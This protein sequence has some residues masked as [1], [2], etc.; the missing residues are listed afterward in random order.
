M[1]PLATGLR[2]SATRWSRTAGLLCI[3]IAFAVVAIAAFSSDAV[4]SSVFRSGQIPGDLRKAINISEVFAHGFGAAAILG[5][6]LLLSPQKRPVIWTAIAITVVS[7]G[8]A[9][10]LKGSIVRIRPLAAGTIQVSGA[11]VQVES[12][13]SGATELV[14]P[15]FWDSRQRSFPSGHAATAWGLAIGLSLA[16]PRGTLLFA[17]FATLASVQRLTSGAHY[18]T[19][20]L[21]G[22]ALAFFVASVLLQIP[23]LRETTDGGLA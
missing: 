18:P 3:A 20:V 22:A 16:F 9:N 19:D 14:Q 13:A 8:L 21:A 23:Y 6:L 15:S 17:G 7:G 5:T 12:H 1:P 11:P 4:L 2:P 10:G